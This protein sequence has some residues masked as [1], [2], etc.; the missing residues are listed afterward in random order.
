MEKYARRKPSERAHRR[1][2]QGSLAAAL[3]QS[4]FYRNHRHVAA[5]Y[6]RVE[7]GQYN[8][9]MGPFAHSVGQVRR[10]ILRRPQQVVRSF[11]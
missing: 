7:L 3:Q 11:C 1:I 9:E 8:R 6:Q 5:T 10:R 4:L 2:L